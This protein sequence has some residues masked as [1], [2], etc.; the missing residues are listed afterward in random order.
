MWEGHTCLSWCTARCA[1][2]V[3]RTVPTPKGTL[4]LRLPAGG[5][6]SWVRCLPTP[7][8]AQGCTSQRWAVPVGSQLAGV[9]PSV[10]GGCS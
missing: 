4:G 1:V 10:V 9:G 3:A 2:C 5:G 7:Q 8:L 6:L